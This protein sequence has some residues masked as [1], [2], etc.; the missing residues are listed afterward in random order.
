MVQFLD[1]TRAGDAMGPEEIL[2]AA[3]PSN[4]D[5]DLVDRFWRRHEPDARRESSLWCYRAWMKQHAKQLYKLMLDGLQYRNSYEKQRECIRE[6]IAVVDAL[7]MEA[8]FGSE[9]YPA[10]HPSDMDAKCPY[11]KAIAAI[12]RAKELL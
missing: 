10:D 6:L 9:S 11:C 12:A 5:V 8:Q 4:G 2:K 1:I 3:S 7:L